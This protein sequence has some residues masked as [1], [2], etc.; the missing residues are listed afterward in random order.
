MYTVLAIIFFAVG[1]FMLNRLKRFY[2]GFYKDFGCYLWM[3]NILLTFP[4][5]FRAVFDW[6]RADERWTDFWFMNERRI[7]SYNILF[8]AFSSL[9]PMVMQIGSLIFGFVRQK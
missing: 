9:I 4:L 5:L 2:K 1:C 3:A 6:L 8:F 7:A